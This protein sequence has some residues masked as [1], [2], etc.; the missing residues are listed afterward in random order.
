MASALE[1][2][3]IADYTEALRQG[4]VVLES[5]L[6][7]SCCSEAYGAQYLKNIP[8]RITEANFG[9]GNPTQYVRE[10][11]VV[12]DLG[13]GAGLNCYVAAQIAGSKGAVIGIDI[14]PSMLQ[15]ARGEAAAF[16]EAT[17]SAPLRFHRAS[18]S[19]LK[20]DQ[21]LAEERL[22]TEPCTDW[23]SWK[24]FEQFVSDSAQTHPLVE[25]QSIDLVI[26]NCVINLVGE[27]EKQNVFA[28]IYRVLKPGGRFAISD[29]VSNVAI[30]DELK[31]DTT[32]WSACY[33]G[34]LQEQAFYQQ[35]QDAGLTGIN[36]E[37][38]NDASTKRI[39]S[40]Q[41][42]SVTVTGTKPQ[43]RKGHPL[44]VIYRGPA[45]ELTGDSGKAY[46]RGVPTELACEDAYLSSQSSVFV[47]EGNQPEQ[48]RPK[49]CCS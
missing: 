15:I 20:I 27:T 33:S 5:Q 47:V 17:G 4:N 2:E 26:S 3:I 8:K 25:D 6:N 11:D 14:N 40:V 19:N 32:L 42:Y 37:A 43:V 9:C 46:K 16:Q 49:S 18:A 23:A 45:R 12:L 30:P 24:N 21:D 31:Q 29:N 7:E 1:N 10:G 39:G 34:V 48:I 38:R 13:S 28:E 41:F 35:L 22:R 44:T 36:I